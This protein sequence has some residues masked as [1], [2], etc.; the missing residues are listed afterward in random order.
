MQ[1]EKKENNAAEQ[2][3]LLAPT[4][5][6]HFPLDNEEEHGWWIACC[7]YS[8]SILAPILW[9]SKNSKDDDTDD[10]SDNENLPPLLWLLVDCLFACGFFIVLRRLNSNVREDAARIY[11]EIQQSIEETEESNNLP[12][13]Q[14]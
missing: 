9:L 4:D 12:S 11:D 1:E 14:C 7:C 10:I 5:N 6:E 2:T 3:Q 13:S 8:L